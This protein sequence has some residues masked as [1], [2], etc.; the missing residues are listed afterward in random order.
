ME[1][2]RHKRD[3]KKAET[4]PNYPYYYD[5]AA[6]DKAVWFMLQLRH[7][8][9]EW[10]GKPFE[11]SDWQE[12]DIVRILFGWKRK[13][14][15]LR[16][17]RTAYIEI[18]RRNGKSF[19]AAA[20]AAYLTIADNEYGAQVYS[21]ATKEAQARIVWEAAKRMIDLSPDLRDEVS[22]YKSSI[23]FPV[24]GS[25]FCP[26]GSDSDKQDG[27]S[28]H[29]A[30]ID[31]YHAHKTS[32]IYDVL[33]SGR[34][35]RRQPLLVII[36]T[37]GLKSVGPCKKESDYAK[38]VLEGVI[39]NDEYFAFVATVDDEEKWEDLDEAI[40]ANP[41][42][43]ISVYPEGYLSELKEAQQSAVKQ[44]SFKTK[45]LNIWTEQKTRWLRVKDWEACEGTLSLDD[46]RGKR[47]F[48]GLDL[49]ITQDLSAFAAA[50]HLGDYEDEHGV[51][52]PLVGLM[53]RFWCPEEGLFQ[54]S[55]EDGVPYQ[56]WAA[57]G[58]IHPTPG[59]TTRYDII[60]KDINEFAEQFEIAEI[61]IDRAHAHQLMVELADD[62]FDIVK[63]A[64]TLMAMN[65]PCRSF[66]ELILQKRIKHEGN[67]VMKWMIANVAIIKDGN[68]N[69]KVVKDKSG[70]RVDGVVAAAMAIGRL[71]IAPSGSH[72]IY[73]NRG[74]FVA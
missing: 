28:V 53:M 32:E 41:N 67:E 4:D 26:I 34:G 39:E 36:T 58:W 70:D 27:F 37:A 54:R 52:L 19:L 47:C 7:F 12:W 13:A 35:S 31:E 65:F 22:P 18:A 16:R 50:F 69:I 66:E 56:L 21:A 9:G 51:M 42:W 71:L 11:L 2:E 30:V 25:R 68:E 43:N 55:H 5:E 57:R 44:N 33:S 3:L 74:L 38:K 49:G 59:N 60:R 61:A 63:H 64:Q 48:C 10:Y 20:I 24:L 72:F 1:R 40:K 62:G 29:G 73:N 6:A 14:N 45:R 46:L 8:D 23:F 17:F 15:G